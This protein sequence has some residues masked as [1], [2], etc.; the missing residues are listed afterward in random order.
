MIAKEEL[1][2]GINKFF[3][4]LDSI[5]KDLDK[6]NKQEFNPDEVQ[7][8]DKDKFFKYFKMTHAWSELDNVVEFKLLP[9]TE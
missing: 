7:Q 9:F 5:S 4:E 8:E 3:D 1:I 6:Y 2:K